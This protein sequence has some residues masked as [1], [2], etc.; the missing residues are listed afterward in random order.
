ME[1]EEALPKAQVRAVRGD[2]TMTLIPSVGCSFHVPQKSLR[3]FL[4][5]KPTH[6][7]QIEPLHDTARKAYDCLRQSCGYP[8][9]LQ[10]IRARNPSALRQ[11]YWS[12][13]G[14]AFINSGFMT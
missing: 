2:L 4:L 10:E 12:Q 7:R 8:V 11:T 13:F 1:A 3:I 6:S 5:Y 14:N 9:A